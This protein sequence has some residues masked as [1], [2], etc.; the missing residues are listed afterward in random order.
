MT[1]QD[2]NPKLAAAGSI[3]IEF[4]SGARLRVS[5]PVEPYTVEA[6]VTALATA[7]TR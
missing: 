7:K 2:Q 4:A 3:D 1:A 6:I 5:G